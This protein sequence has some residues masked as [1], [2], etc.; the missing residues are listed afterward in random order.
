MPSHVCYIVPPYL[1]QGIAESQELG[2]GERQAAVK[3]LQHREAFTNH[4]CERFA[5]LALPRAARNAAL[6]ASSQRKSIVPEVLLQNIVD[7]KDV[8]DDTKAR[9]LKDIE[10]MRHTT[11]AY[12]KSITGEDEPKEEVEEE[13]EEGTGADVGAA[14]AAKKPKKK[15]TASGFY[16]AVHDAKND[17]DE[18]NLPG[19]A[20]RVEGQKPVEDEAANAAYDNIGKVLEFYFEKF[21]WKSIDNR[22]M[23]VVSTVH[24]AEKCKSPSVRTS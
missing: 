10:R 15:P 18:D 3:C 9:A 22:N 4:R 24:F 21:K 16:R 14:S 20:V 8:D 6:Q 2:E 5:A 11:S 19:V 12:Q 7:S 13:E 17:E 23:H 1:L